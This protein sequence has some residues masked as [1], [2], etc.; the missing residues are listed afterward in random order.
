MRIRFETGFELELERGWLTYQFNDANRALLIIPGLHLYNRLQE[1][2][3]S[4]RMRCWLRTGIDKKV[5]LLQNPVEL[6]IPG[7]LCI[8]LLRQ[9]R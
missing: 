1:P 4:C 5:R 3:G 8:Y 7:N 2:Q 9:D 6:S